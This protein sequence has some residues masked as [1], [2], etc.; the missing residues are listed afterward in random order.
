MIPERQKAH[1]YYRCQSKTCS[2]NIVREDRL[3]HA[4][5][6]AYEGVTLAP[7]EAAMLKRDWLAWLQSDG[8]QEVVRSL[9]LRINKTEDR[10]DRLTDLLLDDAIDKAT[11]AERKKALTLQLAGLRDERAEAVKCDLSAAELE[12]FLELITSLAELHI[13]LKPDEKR[14]L[15]E[16]CFSNR[17]VQANEPLLEP[18]SWLSWRDFAELTPLV[19]QIAPLLE[20]LPCRKAS[21]SAD[22]KTLKTP[23]RAISR[24]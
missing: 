2:K 14:Y 4:I 22:P 8:R 15:L 18:H 6:A 5:A 23:Q 21:K 7:A 19:T 24:S 12:E 9:D 11:H 20:L 1:V 16:N 3:E 13:L 10:L 17:T